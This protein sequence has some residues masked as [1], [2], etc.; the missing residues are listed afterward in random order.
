MKPAAAASSNAE[1]SSRRHRVRA[2]ADF[3]SLLQD[4]FAQ[5]Q[6]LVGAWRAHIIMGTA[7][8]I[9]EKIEKAGQK[10]TKAWLPAAFLSVAAGL[11]GLADVDDIRYTLR[12]RIG[13]MQLTSRSG[14]PSVFC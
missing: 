13:A 1:P 12:R 6:Q 11:S 3:Q 5:L 8:A 9:V 4:R 2:H 7:L 14:R 10:P